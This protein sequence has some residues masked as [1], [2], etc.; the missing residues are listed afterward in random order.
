MV[1]PVLNAVLVRPDASLSQLMASN[2]ASASCQAQQGFL[3]VLML[4]TAMKNVNALIMCWWASMVSIQP[5][6]VIY[7]MGSKANLR[8]WL[9]SLMRCS[10]QFRITRRILLQ[11]DVHLVLATIFSNLL[12]ILPVESLDLDKLASTFL[13]LCTIILQ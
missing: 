1:I 6:I 10:Y 5:Q 13:H 7:L 4:T 9:I 12:Y 11:S 2:P 3:G 8:I